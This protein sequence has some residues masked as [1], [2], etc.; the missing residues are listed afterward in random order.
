MPL[1][2]D[3]ITGYSEE[4]H[5]FRIPKAAR[6]RRE[7]HHLRIPKTCG[8]KCRG[9]VCWLWLWLVVVVLVVLVVGVVGLAGAWLYGVGYGWEWCTLS[10]MVPSVVR[11]RGGVVVV[12]G[13]FLQALHD[14]L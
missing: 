12:C 14:H 5:H 9:L 3:S 7:R 1:Q 6:V 8:C 10:Q 13:S 11:D 2:S 4:R